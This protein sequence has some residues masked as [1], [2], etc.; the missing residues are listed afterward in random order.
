MTHRDDSVK[1][2][3]KERYGKS[4]KIKKRRCEVV[5]IGRKESET[6]ES[7]TDG[8]KHSHFPD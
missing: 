6:L 3:K 5:E 4:N 1:Q 7:N 2:A 8:Q